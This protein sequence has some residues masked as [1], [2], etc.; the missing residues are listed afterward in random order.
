MRPPKPRPDTGF[1]VVH[2]HYT[3][4]FPY[5]SRIRS[6]GK[7]TINKG[8]TRTNLILWVPHVFHIRRDTGPAGCHTVLPA[9]KHPTGPTCQYGLGYTGLAVEQVVEAEVQ[10]DAAQVVLGLEQVDALDE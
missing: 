10:V 4:Q 5:Q 9:C 3:L 2:D 8:L 7:S 6:G 1:Q